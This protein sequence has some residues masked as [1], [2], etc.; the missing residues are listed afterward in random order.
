MPDERDFERR[1]RDALRH[2]AD[3]LPFRVDAVSVRERIGPRRRLPSWLLPVAVPVGAAL[4]IAL[5]IVTVLPGAPTEPGLEVGAS[6]DGAVPSASP[7][8][9]PAARPSPTA[10]PS[11]PANRAEAAVATADGRLYLVGGRSRSVPLASAV[12]FDGRLW[13]ELP[14]LPEPRIGASAAVLPDGR[15]VVAGGE[16]DGIPL[17]SSLVLEPGADAWSGGPPM[18]HAQ[19]Y[20]GSTVI[21]GRLYLFGGSEAAHADEMLILDPDDGTWTLGAPMPI[22]AGRIAVAAFDGRAYLFGGVDPTDD[23]ALATTLRYDPSAERWEALADIPGG[24]TAM[25]A[26]IADGRIWVTGP[27]DLQLDDAILSTVFVYDP[28]ANAWTERSDPNAMHGGWHAALLQANGKIL[29]VGGSP[30]F[31]VGSV[32]TTA[33]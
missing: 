7:S 23:G 9:S 1:L 27:A 10:A 24:G 6:V 20:M 19:A 18:P 8:L 33:P 28:A 22:A 2:D 32:D 16:T 3:D 21:D 12:V 31:V 15:L 13:T 4:A 5:V 14:P 25:T 26:T 30:T 29:L 17:S 11:H